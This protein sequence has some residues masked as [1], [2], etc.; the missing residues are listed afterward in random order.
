MATANRQATATNL[1]STIYNLQSAIGAAR[2]LFSVALLLGL[3][4]RLGFVLHG[5][6]IGGSPLILDEGNYVGSA[7]P[8]AQGHDIPD[9]WLWERPPLYIFFTAAVFAIFGSSGT[10]NLLAL[11][12]AQTALS[13]LTIWLVWLI[14]RLLFPARPL[15]AGLAALLVA[16]CPTLAFYA[17]MYMTE[18]LYITLLLAWFYATLRWQQLNANEG[19]P[20]PAPTGGAGGQG[21]INHAPTE[22]EQGGINPAPTTA[23]PITPHSSLLTPHFML[24]ALTF[25]GG[26][27]TR[28]LLLLFLPLLLGWM[29]W[30][31]RVNL[32][33]A[34]S[35][36][37]IYAALVF[38]L[39]LPWSIRNTLHYGRFILIDTT[40][41]INLYIDN[42]PLT[43]SGAYV[44]LGQIP[45]LG[46]RAD[47]AQREALATMFADPG[48]F[49]GAAVS[50]LHD[51]WRV[52][53]FT[54]FQ[55]AIATKYPSTGGST[56]LTYS[57][58][59][60]LYHL[61]FFTLA[62]VGLA[63]ARGEGAAKALALLLIAM[64]TLTTLLAHPEYRYL[65]P[66]FALLAPWAG[67]ALAALFQPRR[68]AAA[69]WLPGAL[70]RATLA[71]LAIA[72]LFYTSVPALDGYAA[73]G[74]AA[75]H[76]IGAQLAHLSADASGEASQLEAALADFDAADLRV[77]LADIRRVQGQTS[78][79]TS[80]YQQALAAD[81]HYW[82]AA[83]D[84]GAAKR[85]SGDIASA[86][87]AF[88][89]IEPSYRAK[90][91]EWAWTHLDWDLRGQISVGVADFGYVRG[92]FEPEQA[93]GHTYRWSSDNAAIHLY[94]T[95][96][97]TTLTLTLRAS[98]SGQ[99]LSIS[100]N[101]Q[102]ASDYQPTLPWQQLDIAI[103]TAL[104]NA[105]D[106]QIQLAVD[107]KQPSAQDP[108]RLGVAVDNA[109]LE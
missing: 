93:D 82:P 8:L 102:P 97:A 12:L 9:R 54:E 76:L 78:V 70:R 87:A 83:L 14:A 60:G 19:G 59:S 53:R 107:A 41:Q 103:P 52:D 48:R 38:A 5:L 56:E 67:R 20:P 23:K 61:L 44:R 92:F 75:Y 104:R 32:R 88:N 25:A 73:G 58:A 13:L 33:R 71:G 35:Q 16:V 42:G 99:R 94:T 79:A 65:L 81:P 85:A 10:G 46:D 101:G 62:I 36:A 89:Q 66:F 18:T 22:S 91:Q 80:L 108:R 50:R 47:F 43:R 45:N 34:L 98:S 40:A 17:N 109:R 64:Q 68:W 29:V 55:V 37:V 63:L 69:L 21:G 4:L 1:Q 31:G 6:D 96:Q 27:L 100:I 86:K 90:A 7:L 2:L 74:K 24:S 84:L 72:L 57:L 49:V 106:Y 105:H 39:I 30:R 28:S 3:A 11:G 26:A 51:A 77:R 95:T 15:A